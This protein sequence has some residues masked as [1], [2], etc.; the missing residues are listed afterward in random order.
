MKVVIN[1]MIY[2]DPRLIGRENF[3]T[4]E[5]RYSDI[6]FITEISNK[7]QLEVLITMPQVVKSMKV[8]EYPNLK[9]IQYLMA[10]YDGVDLN[11]FKQKGIVFS[12]AQDIFSK[13]IAEDVFTK[14]LFFNRHVKQFVQNMEQSIWEPIR[15]EPE[16]TGSNALILGVGSIGKEVAKRFQAFEMNVTGY[17]ATKKPAEHFDS[18][19]T[20]DDEL[21]KALQVADYVVMALPLNEKTDHMFNKEKFTLMK[22]SALFINVGRGPSVNQDDLVEA[23]RNRQIRGAGLDVTEPEPL[24]KDHP[25]WKLDNVYLTPHNASSSPYMRDR[26]FEMICM[27]L[28]LY[29]AGKQVR[30]QINN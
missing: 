28:D 13:S 20:E 23:L 14:I 3:K 16:L 15:E 17:R 11:M 1:L 8:Q 29:L 19:I 5:S 30:Y 7:E 12:N 2:V 26:L 4:L 25:L 27:N 10:G 6:D 22:S 9:W 24:P 18:I 21:N